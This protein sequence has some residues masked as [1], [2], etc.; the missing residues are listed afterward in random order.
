MPRRE[1]TDAEKAEILA[2]L[3]ANAGNVFRTAT[4]WGVAETT[5]R[6][7]AKSR[8][9]GRGVAELRGQKRTDLREMIRGIVE[10]AAGIVPSKL[11]DDKLD[12]VGLMKIVGIGIDKMIALQEADAKQAAPA[13][14][15]ERPG[16][17]R[18]AQY[19]E[20]EK[21]LRESETQTAEPEPETQ[22]V[23]A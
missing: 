8:G 6:G 3:D 12:A 22:E 9:V 20:F 15:N 23:A 19:L 4:E 16:S 7:W 17:N 1:Y 14:E 5:L 11:D 21:A 10:K 2:A 18:I 13:P